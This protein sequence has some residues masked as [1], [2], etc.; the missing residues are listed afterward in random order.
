[1]TTPESAAQ[2]NF[3]RR[4]AFYTTSATHTDPEV[5]ARLV[6][7]AA[8][9]P[10]WSV[11]DIG[12]GAGHT[13]FVL[14]PHVASVLALDLTPE[15]LGEADKLRQKRALLNVGFCIADAHNLPFAD[16]SFDLVTC[17]RAAHH[18]SDIV[19]ALSE[20]RSVLRPGGR[21]VVDDRS[22]PEDDFVDVCMNELDRYHDESHVRQYR[23]SEWARLLEDQGLSLEASEPYIQH[24]ALSTLTEGATEENI[25]RLHDRVR[26]LTQAQRG[27]LNLVE[28]DG[29]LYSNHW[30]LLIS[31]TKL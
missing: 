22:I 27:A 31:A 30:Y 4:A 18:F 17:R 12:T 24:R 28:R 5:L 9:Q 2:R 14:A 29:E 15:M 8:P 7:L 21:V 16:E 25:R 10:N 23:P 20:V 19:G 3:G 26:A 13:A 6:T 11:L 1:M